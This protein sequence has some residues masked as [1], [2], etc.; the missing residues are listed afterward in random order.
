[1][2]HGHA[3]EVAHIALE[4][5]DV[6]VA[7]APPG[8]HLVEPSAG[9]VLGRPVDTARVQG[10]YA[11]ARPGCDLE[12]TVEGAPAHYRG[13]EEAPELGTGRGRDTSN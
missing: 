10:P 4:A 5:G 11:E 12:Q 3:V 1:M 2:P 8:S 9:D 6:E 13:A 7:A